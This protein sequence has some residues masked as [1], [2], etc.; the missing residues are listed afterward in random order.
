MYKTERVL[1][2]IIDSILPKLDNTNMDISY[3]Q[4]PIETLYRTSRSALFVDTLL[5]LD[6]IDKQ[7]LNIVP[8][9]KYFMLPCI[10]SMTHQDWY[11]RSIA[12]NCFAVLIKYYA[13]HVR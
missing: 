12:S 1:Q 11:I 10:Q 5:C 6:V 2:F 3:L 8:Y 9:A 13:L 4:G 7:A